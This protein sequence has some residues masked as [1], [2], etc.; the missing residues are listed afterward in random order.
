MQMNTA[1]TPL[2]RFDVSD[3]LAALPEPSDPVWDKFQLRQKRFKS[4][5]YTRTIAIRWCGLKDA[6]DRPRF[7]DMLYAPQ[8]L[9]DAANRCAEQFESYYDGSAVA[10]LLTELAP[11]QDIPMH[12]DKGAVLTQCHRCHI[13]IVTD[14][15]V[16]FI[17]GDEAFHLEAG[18]AYEFDNVRLHGVKNCSKSARVHLISNV[19]PK[20]GLKVA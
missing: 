9:R 18:Q 4:H 16:Q 6:D 11:G 14:P 13:P 1:M 17:V 19:M 7:M 10:V 15:D 3:I 8:A 20:E 5:S 2:F 12:R